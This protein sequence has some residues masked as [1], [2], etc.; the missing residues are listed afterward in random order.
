MKTNFPN[1]RPKWW[2]APCRTLLMFILLFALP[3]AV[4]A[5]FNYTT[6]NGSITITKYT[7]S[8]GAVTIPSTINGLLVTSIGDMAFFRCTN[9]TS[10]A[11][12]NSVTSIG[13]EAFEECRSLTSVTIG[14]SVTS[15]GMQAFDG[16]TSLTGVTIP[17]SVTW[18]GDNAFFSCTSLTNLTIGTNVTYIGY[19]AFF[20]CT[21]LTSVTIPNSVTSIEDDAF[22]SCQRLTGVGFEGNAPSLGSG[23][24]DGPYVLGT[25]Y[26]DSQAIIYYLPGTTG[27]GWTFGGCPTVLWNPQVL[28]SAASFG[29]WTNPGVWT[30]QFGF[31]VVGNS[32]VRVVV[33]ACTNLANPTWIPVGTSL[34]TGGSSYFSDPQWAKYPARFYRLRSP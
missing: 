29:I 32:N 17:N 18:I 22:W 23:V 2:A 30:N 25:Y 7:D 10:V 12:P 28:T 8:G 11:I 20:G 27:W 16:C 34:L 4:Q 33:E 1:L 19:D 21:S 6:N 9:L 14:N 15:I 24:F 31:P 26:G 5:Q 13:T 3:A